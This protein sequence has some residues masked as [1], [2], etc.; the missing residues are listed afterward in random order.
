[1]NENISKIWI[2]IEEIEITIE[3]NSDFV[4]KQYR[5][6]FGEKTSPQNKT[7]HPKSKQKGT[8]SKAKSLKS[9]GT[10]KK[11]TATSNKPI[12]NQENY[13]NVLNK[14]TNRD[15]VLLTAYYVTFNKKDNV[16]SIRELIHTF[17]KKG[18]EILNVAKVIKETAFEEKIIK[19]ILDNGRK[20]YYFTKQ[21]KEYMKELLA[22]EG[23]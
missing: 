20:Y 9:S 17:S 22:V 8:T 23:K 3:G 6:I 13:S 2:K 19:P 18:I 4:S 14:L 21:G 15:K 12:S 10:K 11:K 1:M 5:E 7:T 16:F